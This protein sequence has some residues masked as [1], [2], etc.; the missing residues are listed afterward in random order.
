[1][2]EAL[3]EDQKREFYKNFLKRHP[4]LEK[5]IKENFLTVEDLEKEIN[6][7]TEKFEEEGNPPW[8][9]LQLVRFENILEDYLQKNN[10]QW[11]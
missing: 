4:L 2:W 3:N 10:I 1:M 8:S 5:F 6:T 11:Y 9:K 7:L